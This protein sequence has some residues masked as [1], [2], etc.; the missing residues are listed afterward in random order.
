MAA[1]AAADAEAGVA[2]GLTVGE[3]VAV[4]VGDALG[5]V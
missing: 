3:G 2:E 5:G 1:A 4:P